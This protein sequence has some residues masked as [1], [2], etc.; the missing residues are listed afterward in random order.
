[1]PGCHKHDGP[2]EPDQVTCDS[3]DLRTPNHDG[4][5]ED[6]NELNHTELTARTTAQTIVE[7]IVETITE[8]ITEKPHSHDS[9][10]NG[11]RGATTDSSLFSR[12]KLFNQSYCTRCAVSRYP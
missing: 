5:T 10:W 1:M 3:T 9:Y 12:F 8:T 7:T 11:V 4:S 6:V 2:T